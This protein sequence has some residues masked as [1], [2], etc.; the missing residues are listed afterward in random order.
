MFYTNAV[1]HIRH[2]RDSLCKVFCAA[3]CLAVFYGPAEFHLTLAYGY[4]DFRGI[5][6]RVVCKAVVDVVLY[7][8]VR[9]LVAFWP[10]AFVHS[11][12]V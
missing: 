8:F 6:L 7:A 2:T 10:L 1:L 4:F 3:L 5:Q 9:A 11:V 12:I